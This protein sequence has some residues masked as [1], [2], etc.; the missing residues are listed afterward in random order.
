MSKTVIAFGPFRAQGINLTPSD[1]VIGMISPSA[2]MG[3][4]GAIAHRLG[5]PLW[6][7]RV[8]LVV[9]KVEEHKGRLRGEQTVKN[10]RLIPL[11]TPEALTGTGEFSIIAELPGQHGA[12]E[13]MQIITRLRFAGGG[14]FPPQGKNFKDIVQIIGPGNFRKILDRLPRGMV[15]GPPTE[16]R[17]AGTISFGEETSL[18]EIAMRA[19]SPERKS[20]GGYIVPAPVG[21][22]VLH[23]TLTDEPPACC[24]DRDTPFALVDTAVGLAEFVSIRNRVALPDLETSF[25]QRGWKWDCDASNTHKMFSPFHLNSLVKV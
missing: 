22:R 14:I 16:N 6:E 11:E 5:E 13:I 8:I 25:S 24:R 1:N 2:P 19:Y 4:V 10:G 3:F 15:F 20:E 23:E 12:E 18:E 21:Y 17:N 9:H 7:H